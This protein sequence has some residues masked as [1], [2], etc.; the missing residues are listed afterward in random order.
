MMAPMSRS[1][2]HRRMSQIKRIAL[3]LGVFFLGCAGAHLMVAS[4]A[5]AATTTQRWEYS[6]QR[7]TDDITKMANG[8]GAQG[9]ELTAAAGAGSG[10]GL[11]QNQTM[12]WCFKRP[13]P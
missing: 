5:R 13:L 12:V 7:A 10:T 11:G 4:P 8:L 2:D 6:C 3:L 1:G 9:W